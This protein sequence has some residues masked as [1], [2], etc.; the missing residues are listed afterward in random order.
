MV[1]DNCLNQ[2]IEKSGLTKAEV[3]DTVTR[4]EKLLREGKSSEEIMNEF[5]EFKEKR[6]AYVKTMNQYNLLRDR[7]IT[8]N[9]KSRVMNQLRD[10]KEIIRVFGKDFHNPLQHAVFGIIR[11]HMHHRLNTFEAA[12]QKLT[13]SLD[14][15]LI[16]YM[17]EPSNS[18]NI[19][20]EVAAI[21]ADQTR[22]I[23]AT[24][25]DK[26]FKIAKAHVGI[27]E[28]MRH[29]QSA[30]GSSKWYRKDFIFSQKYD[31]Y[32]VGKMSD[33]DFFT[34]LKDAKWA[35]ADMAALDAAENVRM[36]A[37]MSEGKREGKLDRR[38]KQGKAQLEQ[39]RKEFFERKAKVEADALK[40]AEE[41]RRAEWIKF[42]REIESGNYQDPDEILN[43]GGDFT[44][45]GSLAEVSGRS[46][47]IELTP[48]QYLAVE[49]KLF[50][51]KNFKERAFLEYQSASRV[52]ADLEMFGS[53][54]GENFDKVM[55][56]LIAERKNVMGTEMEPFFMRGKTAVL[57]SPFFQGDGKN[58][59]ILHKTM[60]GQKPGDVEFA[61]WMNTIRGMD[62]AVK[63]GGSTITAFTDLT[64][65]ALQDALMSGNKVTPFEA[66]G[67]SVDLLRRS[68]G[69]AE[70]LGVMEDV[71]T[72]AEHVLDDLT[73]HIRSEDAT[74]LNSLDRSVKAR[75]FLD[76]GSGLVFGLNQLENWTKANQRGSFVMAM[77][78]FAREADNTLDKVSPFSR[79]SLEAFGITADE[80]DFIR[81]RAKRKTGYGK[82]ILSPTAL[83]ELDLTEYKRFTDTD[84]LEV[85][86]STRN[87]IVS[88]WQNMI[89]GKAT[90]LTMMP[91]TID[92]ARMLRGLQSGTITGEAAR[93]SMMYKSFMMGYFGRV[94]IP[95]MRHANAVT[96]A[97][98]T[99]AA[100]SMAMA[101]FTLKDLAKGRTPRDFTKFENMQGVFFHVYGLPYMDQFAFAVNS[102]NVQASN[103][104]DIAAGPVGADAADTFVRTVNLLKDDD[105]NYGKYITRTFAPMTPFRNHWLTTGIYNQGYN[106]AMRHFD[107]NYEKNHSKLLEQIGQREIGFSNGN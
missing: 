53:K 69:D 2:L 81:S 66:I 106:Y 20:R 95:Q 83:N 85:L 90:T 70:A 27:S 48:E 45:S 72:G 57:E 67:D 5:L 1:G 38:T 74:Q 63:L 6:S 7:S 61:K 39:N 28:A 14:D 76:K 16:A 101:I 15:D 26:A 25:D 18:K 102:D 43:G 105:P 10:P 86:A 13:R 79:E 24:G 82:G 9:L 103:I 44:D 98:Y 60:F 92:S 58:K 65:R 3:L 32:K 87:E 34:L 59:S 22:S 4:T 71:L 46:R 54:P 64:V 78:Q 31:D 73:T 94:F 12:A 107:P 40:A 52:I 68:L 89:R 11:Q 33:D 96:H 8:N 49:D 35:K 93:F 62:A 41:A 100:A 91:D 51:G 56:S 19:Y 77:A 36:K 37:K 17:G 47:S 104:Y 75:E 23:S 55:N 30:A 29:R 97:Q 50:V 42:K 80:W 21:R 88:K 99:I 84:N